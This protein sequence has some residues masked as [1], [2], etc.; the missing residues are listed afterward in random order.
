MLGPMAHRPIFVRRTRN[1]WPKQMIEAGRC[2]WNSASSERSVELTQARALDPADGIL[3]TGQRGRQ[4]HPPR[5]GAQRVDVLARWLVPSVAD[6]TRLRNE[7]PARDQ[8][9]SY[10]RVRKFRYVC[11]TV[12]IF[13]LYKPIA[14]NP[15]HPL[16]ALVNDSWR[17]VLGRRLSASW[18]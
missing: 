6:R 11:F 14:P 9:N 5:R 2:R 15:D 13:R 7:P 10:S 3:T 4:P 1:C 18:T 12:P 8:A 16:H 17:V